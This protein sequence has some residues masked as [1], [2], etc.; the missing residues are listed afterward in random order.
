MWPTASFCHVS[1]DTFREPT[2]REGWFI[3]TVAEAKVS[4]ARGLKTSSLGRYSRRSVP[5]ELREGKVA[6]RVSCPGTLI[7]PSGSC[8]IELASS[9]T[10]EY[11]IIG[12]NT[13]APPGGYRP[14]RALDSVARNLEGRAC[15]LVT[16]SMYRSR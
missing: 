11:R 15:L 3:V 7:A 16:S 5:S 12:H 2:P 13:L 9:R 6:D 8:L 14:R 1:G 10:S 4:L